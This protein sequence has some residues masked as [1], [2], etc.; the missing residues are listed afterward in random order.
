VTPGQNRCVLPIAL[1]ARR[2]KQI[3]QTDRAFE[4]HGMEGDERL[5]AGFGFGI[6][7][8]LLLVIDEKSPF[9]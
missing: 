8:D 2:L 3:D 7:E 4:R 5:L 9:L 1:Q 6:L